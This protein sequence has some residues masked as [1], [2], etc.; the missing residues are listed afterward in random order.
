[1]R[2]G[3]SWPNLIFLPYDSLLDATTRNSLGLQDS[4][5]ERAFYSLVAVHEMAHQW[6][7]HLVGWKTYHDQWLSEGIAE[8][9]SS[10]YVRQF[11]PKDLSGFW[12]MKRTYLLSKNQYGYRPVDAGP[13]WLNAQIGS[14][15]LLYSKGAYVMEMLRAIM[16][17]PRTKNPDGHFIAMMQD[18][19]KSY[20][21]QNAS[22]E[23]FRKIVEKH[24][25]EPMEWF[26]NEWVYGTAI[27][28]YDFSYAMADAGGG[29][30]ELTMT[31]TQ[32]NVG[33]SFQM[34]L[35]V[36]IAVQGEM[37]YLGTISAAGTKPQKTSVK[38]PMRPDKI[39]L[40]PGRSILAEIR[41]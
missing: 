6:W 17:D 9:A 31:I 1:M 29:Q 18:F 12:G 28:T 2:S 21:G 8:F 3:Q 32:S 16:Y 25:G 15:D 23:D 34:R 4:G 24:M 5:E 22:T 36:Y 26:F 14:S 7:G 40:D 10:M 11:Q 41:Q 39:V 37:R 30:T 19:V 38:L 13:I 35:P 27:P 20:A 33:E